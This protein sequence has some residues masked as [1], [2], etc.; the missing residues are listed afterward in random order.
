MAVVL[1][2]VLVVSVGFAGLDI[3]NVSWQEWAIIAA[4]VFGTWA[5]WWKTRIPRDPRNC[6]GF[7]SRLN[8]KNP[9]SW[10]NSDPISCCGYAIS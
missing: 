1:V 5:V 10:S 2:G 7:A 4:W 3:G 9:P 8:L 6:V